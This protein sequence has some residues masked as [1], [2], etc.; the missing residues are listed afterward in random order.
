VLE[1]M[2]DGATVTLLGPTSN[3]FSNVS[4]QGTE[5][6]AFSAFLQ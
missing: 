1:V 6:W 2:P 3:G 4:Y 5:G